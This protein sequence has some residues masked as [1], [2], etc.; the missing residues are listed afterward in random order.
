MLVSSK[1]RITN[2]LTKITPAL[3]LKSNLLI[4][5][6]EPVSISIVLGV[7]P[8]ITILNKVYWL[9][10]DLLLDTVVCLWV[11]LPLTSS[12]PYVNAELYVFAYVDAP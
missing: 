9:K 2:G 12:I 7:S 5:E 3:L 8:L 10:F 6:D 1:S 4:C 11:I